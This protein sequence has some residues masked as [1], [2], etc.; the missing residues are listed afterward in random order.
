MIAAIFCLTCFIAV[1]HGQGIANPKI[2]TPA[3]QLL[4]IDL[5]SRT[6]L[7]AKEI[8]TRMYPASITKVMTAYIIFD[9]IKTGFIDMDTKFPISYKARRIGGSRMFVEQGTHVTVKDLL[10]GLIVQSGNDAAIALAEGISGS[11]QDFVNLMNE[12]AEELNMGN[13]HFTNASG[14][15]DENHYTTAWDLAVLAK[16]TIEDYP[17]YY[18][19]Y[20]ETSF[21]YNGITQANRNPLLYQKIG[22][23]G[24]KT[25][26][27][28]V[29]GYGLLAS[30][31]FDGRRM[32]LVMN[33]LNSKAARRRE[34]NRILRW[35]YNVWD[36][37][38]IF[39]E[40]TLVA[41]IPVSFGNEKQLSLI[42]SQN[43]S[44]TIPKK[45]KPNLS[46][47]VEYKSP[48]IAPVKKGDVIGVLVIKEN[49]KE[50]VRSP[51]IAAQN[52][53]RPNFIGRLIYNLGYLF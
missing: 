28:E 2:T 14:W 34:S 50:V 45:Y 19:I 16:R 33:G 27:T 32:L 7:A 15:P 8:H 23:D 42:A 25:G 24:L 20:A 22:V 46:G 53:E 13:T 9:H 21:K 4:I 31:V 3:K 40:G 43:V 47:Y 10:Y 26:H 17:K 52:I 49:D 18:K 39:P 35:S 51:V 6:V 48:I 29:S 37:I 1:S 38:K 30:S 5:D 36:N 41:E 44:I 11:E 12:T